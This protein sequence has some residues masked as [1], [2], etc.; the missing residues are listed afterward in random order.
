MY[1]AGKSG[2]GAEAQAKIEAKYDP[3][4]AAECLEWV[5]TILQSNDPPISFETSGERQNFISVLDDGYVLANL[6]NTLQ[7]GSIPASKL[8]SR[9]KMQFKKMELIELF[10]E[11]L[12][13]YGVVDH[14]LFAT[15]DLTES[16]DL[17]QVVICL[18]ALGR[19]AR[20]NGHVGLGP[21]ESEGNVR[22][23]T[24]EQLKAGQNVI[25]LQYG[26]N[27]GASQAGMNFGKSRMIID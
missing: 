12:K 1:R 21:K 4:Q 24:E 8:K 19:K 18:Q 22:N 7:P 13:A 10:L 20:M 16:Q 23:F 27:K 14:E 2:L 17:N 15:I 6:I 25:S 9:P 3:A 5:Q 11:K 26:S